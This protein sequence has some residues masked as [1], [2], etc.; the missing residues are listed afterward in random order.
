MLGSSR[1]RVV[2]KQRILLVKCLLKYT[3]MNITDIA[4]FLN[5]TRST[6]KRQLREM[7]AHPERYFS[8]KMLAKIDEDLAG[9]GSQGSGGIVTN[10]VIY[11]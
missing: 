3:G 7:E 2:A 1:N 10:Q 11:K 5:R 4:E 9:L 8:Q 6:L